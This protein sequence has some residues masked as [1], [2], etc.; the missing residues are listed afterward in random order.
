MQKDKNI[1]ISTNYEASS[2]INTEKLETEKQKKRTV[3]NFII[4]SLLL[5]SV[6]FMILSGL[7]LQQGFH[8]SDAGE[9]LISFQEGQHHQAMQYEQVR[10]ID[11]NKIVW[12]LNYPGW[13]TV[14]RLFIVFFSLLIIYHVY[15]HRIWYK[16]A[17]RKNLIRKNIQ[18]F[19]LSALFFLVAVTGFASWFVDL[20]GNSLILRI[21]F[22]EIHDKLA[23]F[24]IV[25]LM[26]HVVKRAKW[27][28]AV[29]EKLKE[30]VN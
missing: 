23:L 5:V 2:K 26:L 8:R 22:I 12:G 27:F 16:R 25:F 28:F 14:H 30:Q 11:S 15:V 17:I 19:I 21:L 24:L 10:G 1:S 9:Q 29:H 4:N 7:V 3:N 6:L 13:S 20:S 18:M